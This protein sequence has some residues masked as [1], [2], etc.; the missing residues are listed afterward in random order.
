MQYP[1]ITLVTGGIASGKSR[2]AETLATQIAT[3]SA[4][5][6]V[7]YI[8]TADSKNTDTDMQAKI[9]AHRARRPKHWH[10]QEH[11]Y[12][13]PNAV[14]ALPKGA[15]VLI[16]CITLWISNQIIK[17]ANSVDACRDL[18]C[19][20]KNNAAVLILVSQEAGHSIIAPT[21]KGRQFQNLQGQM[22]QDL[23]TQANCFVH[24]TAGYP[25]TIKGRLP[26]A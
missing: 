18:C 8:A 25:I 16:D 21:H 5:D 4:C 19:A 26:V 22:N 3:I 13:L 23:A 10:T 15:V 14:S 9:T 6:N 1:K 20:I 24:I 2:F 12:A 17:N 7:I 11:P